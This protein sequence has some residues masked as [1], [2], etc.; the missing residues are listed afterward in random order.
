M[1]LSNSSIIDGTHK[2]SSSGIIESAFFSK[3]NTEVAEK[4]HLFESVDVDGHIRAGETFNDARNV[5]KAAEHGEATR[6]RAN[7][8]LSAVNG[9]R[10]TFDAYENERANV[11]DYAIN[12]GLDKGS[13]LA[14][15]S[16]FRAASNSN[17]EAAACQSILSGNSNLQVFVEA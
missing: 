12:H 17:E 5:I 7:N 2:Q 11:I 1:R 4:K 10:N 14:M 15:Y 3:K 9:T 13:A 8:M 6:D 16:F